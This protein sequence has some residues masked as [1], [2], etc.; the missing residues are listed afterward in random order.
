MKKQT[1]QKIVNLVLWTVVIYFATLTG[2]LMKLPEGAYIHIGDTAVYIAVLV[3]PFYAAAPCAAVGCALA[4]ITLGS[5]GYAIATVIIKCATVAAVKLLLKLSEKPLTQDV[6]VCLAGAVTVGGYYLADVLR[7]VL[8]GGS[9]IE[10]ME[11]AFVSI[12]YNVLQA[13]ICAVLYVALSGF[14][15]GY[16]DKRKKKQTVFDEVEYDKD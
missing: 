14:V 15:R 7:L 13:L 12:L 9:F 10:S 2:G 5:T 4:D 8:S 16:I 3:L 6:L 11:G 1:Y